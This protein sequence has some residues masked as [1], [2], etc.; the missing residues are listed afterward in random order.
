MRTRFSNS[1]ALAFK[2]SAW[3]VDQL[4]AFLVSSTGSVV[5][6]LLKSRNAFNG[7]IIVFKRCQRVKGSKLL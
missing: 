5:A 7:A 2:R 3:R 6:W 1:F 4:S